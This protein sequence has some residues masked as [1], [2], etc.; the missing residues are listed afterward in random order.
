MPPK[1]APRSCKP[2]RAASAAAAT[3]R[4]LAAE[5]TP[6]PLGPAAPTPPPL[7]PPPP[8]LCASAAAARR[9]LASGPVR[10]A[11]LPL[12]CAAVLVAGWVAFA[13]ELLGP[14]K[15]AAAAAAAALLCAF[16]AAGLTPPVAA[17]R[18]VA[19]GSHGA[20]DGPGCTSSLTPPCRERNLHSAWAA[21]R[22]CIARVCA[23]RLLCRFCRQAKVPL[24]EADSVAK[25]CIHLAA[26]QCACR[27]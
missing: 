8:K 26:M 14:V 22:D 18:T 3:A 19:S 21:S 27:K 11:G 23:A 16:S 20:A 4:S 7:P 24:C 15:A 12:P 25:S 9:R 5:S 6:L 13:S 10:R 17:R 1:A 2:W